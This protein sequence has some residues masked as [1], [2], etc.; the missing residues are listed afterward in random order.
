[1]SMGCRCGACVAL[2]EVVKELVR[3]KHLDD[4]DQLV[5]VVVAM[6]EG[7]LTENHAREHAPERPPGMGWGGG[8]HTVSTARLEAVVGSRLGAVGSTCRVL[9]RQQVQG[10]GA[11]AHIQRVVI[12]LQVDEELRSLEVA[13]G[14]AHV[15]L[16]LQVVKLGEAPVYQ[17][18][19]PLLRRGRTERVGEGSARWQ[20]KGWA[21]AESRALAVVRALHGQSSRCAV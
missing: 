14:D 18:Q 1:M 13:R 4:L 6:E 10:R 5:V 2:V 21:A 15:V 8:P 20:G 17:A 19:L 12:V 3:P 16:A 9:G 7:L 11:G